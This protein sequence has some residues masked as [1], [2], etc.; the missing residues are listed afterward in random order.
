MHEQKEE[1]QKAINPKLES[2]WQT[3][4]GYMKKGLS[5]RNR[6]WWFKLG[7]AFLGNQTQVADI[8]GFVGRPEMRKALCNSLHVLYC[9]CIGRFKTLAQSQ[10]LLD[11]WNFIHLLPRKRHSGLICFYLFRPIG[12][13]EHTYM[14]QPLPWRKQ[15]SFRL[16]NIVGFIG[17][18]WWLIFML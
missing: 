17:I 4:F 11:I 3:C 7:I 14:G 8:G 5:S 9:T 15:E 18:F 12:Q 16:N 13:E 1:E 6:F 2:T 10:S